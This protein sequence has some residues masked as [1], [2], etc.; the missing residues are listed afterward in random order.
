MMLNDGVL[1]G[2]RYLSPAAVAQMTSKQ[3][4]ARVTQGYG[5][6]WSTDGGT[7]GHAGAYAVNMT[8]DATRGLIMVF[9]VQHAGFLGDGSNS[10]AA[11]KQA[12]EKR[13]GSKHDQPRRWWRILK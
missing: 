5:L 4:G 11:F 12:V 7:F 8:I 10:H 1:D 13:F 2:T 9:L 3:T 6:G